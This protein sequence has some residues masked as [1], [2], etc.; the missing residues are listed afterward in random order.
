MRISDWSSDVCSSDLASQPSRMLR[1]GT[2]TG[3]VPPSGPPAPPRRSIPA[4][5]SKEIEGKT[6]LLDLSDKICKW[7]IGN[8]GEPDFHFCGQ[9][10]SEERR[11][12]KGCVRN[13]RTRGGT[14]T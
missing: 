10:R 6:T 4:K 9:P 3:P 1:P 2:P 8:P 13:C 7:T 12:G 5:P 11:V 14:K